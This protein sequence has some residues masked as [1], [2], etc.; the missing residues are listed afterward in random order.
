[1]SAAGVKLFDRLPDGLFAPLAAPN[2]R[3]Y[4]KLFCQL[5]DRRFGPHAPLP[6]P[7]GFPRAEI[8]ADF[9][10]D[11]AIEDEG[12]EEPPETPRN[13]RAVQIF[14]TF[15]DAGWF[16]VDRVGVRE[17][18]SIRPA[19][20]QFMDRLVDFAERGPVFLSGKVRSIEANLQTVMSGQ[21]SGDTLEETAAQARQLMEFVRNTGT[22]VRDIMELV[23]NEENIRGYV[24]RFFTDFIEQVFIA[25]YRDLRTREHPLTRRP[26][27]LRMV[28]EL[29]ASREH[30]QRLLSW[31][32][33][34]RT[35][36]DRERAMYLLERDL[37]RIDDIRRIDEY[38]ERLD[39][40]INRANRRA[41]AY[42]DYRLRS[43][44]PIDS[45]VRRAMDN[46]LSQPKAAAAAPFAA[47]ALLGPNSLAQPRA[48][49]T[50]ATA[51]PLRKVSVSIEQ[52]ARTMLRERAR[53][54]RIVTPE[55]MTAYLDARM[56]SRDQADWSTFTVANIH[57]FRAL[58]VLM[59]AA[60]GNA[61]GNR[62]LLATSLRMTRGR[63]ARFTGTEEASGPHLSSVPFEVVS[64]PRVKKE[65][66]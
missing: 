14:H 37:A 11:L 49:T 4:W 57:D 42:L 12:L 3:L 58:Q 50:R 65:S 38:L 16:R 17:V 47:G 66:I 6:P 48:V 46:V 8:I 55:K 23:S 9:D 39:D 61:S 7:N 45:M 36:G 64:R 54:A 20:G 5:Y 13:I 1:M 32:E 63:L 43:L 2:R 27:I 62:A 40:E 31:Y 25:D 29:R 44:R 28:E 26:Q 35:K 53:E 56:G 41:I 33:A 15:A 60:A 19:V 34:N 18:V 30:D 21:G 52:T 51:V 22:T 24:R 10:R 59:S